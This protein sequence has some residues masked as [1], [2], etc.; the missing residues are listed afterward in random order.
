MLLLLLLLPLFLV[1]AA[2]RKICA[3]ID[4]CEVAV[5]LLELKK[6]LGTTIF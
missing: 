3:L 4:A 1:N 2:A 6:I 5:R